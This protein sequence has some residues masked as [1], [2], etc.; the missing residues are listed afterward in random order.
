VNVLGI[1]ADDD[2][3]YQVEGG[4]VFASDVTGNVTPIA[5][6]NT[7]DGGNWP[8]AWVAGKLVFV[9][10]DYTIVG[11]GSTA[12][13]S[14]Y[15]LSVWSKT[16]GTLKPVATN[17]WGVMN[18]ASDS[19]YFVLLDQEAAD[20]THGNIAVAAADGTGLTDV[21]TDVATDLISATTCA[22]WAAFDGAYLV[23]SSCP[24]QDAGTGQAQIASFTGTGWAT[25]T[26]LAT[27][28]GPS[29]PYVAPQV[30]NFTTDT[31]GDNVLTLNGAGDLFSQGIAST[32]QTALAPFGTPTGGSELFYLST[33][34]QFALFTDATG[35]LQKA[36]YA[37]PASVPTVDSAPLAAAGTVLGVAA[38]SPDENYDVDFD[39]LG[40]A[41]GLS[42]PTSL[43][44]RNIQ[45][46]AVTSLATDLSYT[47]AF[48]DDGSYVIYSANLVPVTGVTGLTGTLQAAN[49]STGAI[50]VQVGGTSATVWDAAPLSG[51]GIIYNQN[52]K[53]FTNVPS[54]FTVPNGSASADI[55]I[56][57]ATAA[58]PGTLLV[59]GADA[60]AGFYVTSDKKH[61]FYSF[62]QLVTGDGGTVVLA[63][64]DGLYSIAIP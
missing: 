12:Y 49:V 43:N 19:S 64:G 40:T 9:A 13:Y 25:R 56:A 62:T 58:S 31:I 39:S 42:I 48:T 5:P 1:T 10:T 20:V 14:P 47:F 63:N 46:G 24:F 38:I 55:Y 6:P 26:V 45:T 36:T 23:T 59:T 27:S 8:T 7:T 16:L 4:G 3:V 29:S 32:T 21:V 18:V 52:Y 41:A 53:P 17:A 54:G 51:T 11:S 33:K 34:S 35:A 50:N 57:D 2:I 60:P 30:V 44:L 61:L 28:A 15:T 22:P 37:S